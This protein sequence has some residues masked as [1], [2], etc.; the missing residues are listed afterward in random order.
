MKRILLAGVA[1]TALAVANPAVAADLPVKA[2]LLPPVVWNWTGFYAGVET[3]AAWGITNFGDPFGGS[4]YGDDVRTPGWFLGGDVGFNWQ[5]GQWVWGLE[6]TGDW[7]RSEGTNTCAA[8]SGFY[9][10]ANCQAN[11]RAF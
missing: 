11:P 2:P 4:I 3:G 10:S 8:F 6:A 7:L 5:N 9:V 1:L